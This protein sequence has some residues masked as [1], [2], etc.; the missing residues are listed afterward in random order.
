MAR[1]T[2]STFRPGR[3][4]ARRSRPER[5]AATPFVCDEWALTC[6]TARELDNAGGYPT[7]PEPDSAPDAAA[8]LAGLAELA[9]STVRETAVAVAALTARGGDATSATH[10]TQLCER[11]LDK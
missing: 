7:P 9:L 3:Y 5:L 6:E 11:A 4:F 8:Q 1:R 2:T 10:L